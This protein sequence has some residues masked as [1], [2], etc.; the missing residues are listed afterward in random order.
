M[1][2]VADQKPRLPIHDNLSTGTK[3]HRDD[4]Y[5]GRIGLSQ[6]QPKALRDGI[7]VEQRGGG[8]EQLVFA[9]HIDR[10]YVV[11]VSTIEMRFDLLAKIGFI[12]NDARDD[13]SAA[14]IRRA[15]SI[16]R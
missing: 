11:D 2:D 7:Q 13:Q 10:A 8:R 15:T 14:G 6:D 16:A 4:R 1:L 12:L 5:A 9:H 3:I